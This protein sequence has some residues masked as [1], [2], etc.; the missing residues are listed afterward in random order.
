MFKR[1]IIL[2]VKVAICQSVTSWADVHELRRPGPAFSWMT[3]RS[4]LAVHQST[5]QKNSILKQFSR[6]PP[7]FCLIYRWER[8]ES[9]PNMNLFVSRTCPINCLHH[10]R[11]IR[12]SLQCKMTQKRG[13]R[14]EWIPGMDPPPCGE[15]RSPPFPH[16]VGRGLPA[17]PQPVKWSKP[18]EVARQNKGPIINFFFPKEETNDGTILQHWTM[19]NPVWKRG[20]QETPPIAMQ[21]NASLTIQYWELFLWI[22]VERK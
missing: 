5:V 12:L 14:V 8:G 10:L 1:R 18:G 7:S 11:L 22:I 19:P 15:G 9:G 17:R 13:G 21:C 6:P 20:I 2:L 4:I 16:T 3:A